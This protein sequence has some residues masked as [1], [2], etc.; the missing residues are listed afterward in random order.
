[1]KYNIPE[2]SKKDDIIIEAINNF[3]DRNYRTPSITEIEKETGI[4][5]QT[6]QRR[7]VRMDNNGILKYDGKL[8][9][10]VTPY[11]ESEERPDV[12]RLNILGKIACGSPQSEIE[13]RLGVIDFP[14]A[15]LGL[16]DYFI[17]KADGGSM[18][19]A[20]IDDGDYVIVKR[21]CEAKEGDI[22]VAMNGNYETTL[23]TLKFN[24]EE[25]CYYL[26]PEASGYKDI[27]PEEIDIRGVAKRVIKTL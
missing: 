7:L 10:I 14:R 6:V 15:L 27:Y 21:T 8:K 2:K 26:H 22:V 19:N 24:N 11:M 23:K 17:L 20:G 5:R 16:G 12:V 4:P 1:M 18:V 9:L 25:Q 3:F 13:N